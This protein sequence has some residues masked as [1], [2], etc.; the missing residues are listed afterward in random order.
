MWLGETSSAVWLFTSR[1]HPHGS[2]L[3][4]YENLNVALHVGDDEAAVHRNRAQVA[5]TL[6]VAPNQL[7]WPLL[8]HT[9]TAY[10]IKSTDGEVPVADILYTSNPEIAITT[11]SADCVP[12]IAIAQSEPFILTAHIGW[13]GAASNIAKEISAILL[14]NTKG[15]V[16]IFLGPAI[17]GNCYQVDQHRFG[18]VVS[19][20]PEAR[21]SENGLDLRKGLQT[22]FEN[23]GFTVSYVGPCT[24][25]SAN[26]FSYRRDGITG[27]Q[28][29]VVKLR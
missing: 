12:V 26:L 16:E 10:H 17:C 6:N 22:H 25:E 15:K 4:A 8:E 5:T 28:A 23:Q 9:T 11:M 18:D 2:S 19:K 24:F 20:L 21:A 29:A 27:R 13:K 3:G 14:N 7:V 1:Y